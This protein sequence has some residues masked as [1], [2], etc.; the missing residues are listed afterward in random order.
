MINK[1]LSTVNR[2]LGYFVDAT[3]NMLTQLCSLA[4][5]VVNVAIRFALL[6]LLYQLIAA[7][8][9]TVLDGLFN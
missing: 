3:D 5:N 2:L 7:D 8:L 4:V 9:P 1:F 6:M